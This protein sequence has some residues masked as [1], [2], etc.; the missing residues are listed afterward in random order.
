MESDTCLGRNTIEL[1]RDSFGQTLSAAVDE[2]KG[3]DDNSFSIRLKEPFPLLIDALAKVS[4]LGHEVIDAFYVVD[5]TGSKL[6]D[7]DH[8]HEIQRGIAVH[9][10]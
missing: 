8:L 3:G 2:M 6:T 9:L 7:E 5:Q 10:Q 4:S 1:A